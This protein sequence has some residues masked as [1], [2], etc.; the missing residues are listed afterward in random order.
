MSVAV[1]LVGRMSCESARLSLVS[2]TGPAAEA[3]VP[4]RMAGG[5]NVRRSPSNQRV[6][7]PRP[8]TTQVAWAASCMIRKLRGGCLWSSGC[9]PRTSTMSGC[10]ARSLGMRVVRSRR[11][12]RR[13]HLSKVRVR[14]RTTRQA[15]WR[16]C[17]RAQ[18]SSTDRPLP[19]VESFE[20]LGR[21]RS[22][23]E[24]PVWLFGCHWP[25]VSRECKGHSSS[26]LSPGG[27]NE[28]GGT[29]FLLLE[30]WGRAERR[31]G[32]SMVRPASCLGPVTV[33][34]LEDSFAGW[35]SGLARAMHCE[36]RVG[37]AKSSMRHCVRKPGS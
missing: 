31:S 21:H 25:A 11:V 30:A 8:S 37:R 20:R 35:R 2:R 9:P 6:R 32:V 17:P 10:S 18:H 26:H 19:G 1:V 5:D 36:C 24:R 22:K 16:G 34:K 3:A 15:T 29:I 7:E 28:R 27:R 13:R 4:A 23:T 12:P 33:G 14:P